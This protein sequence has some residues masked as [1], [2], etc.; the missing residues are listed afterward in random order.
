[1]EM[2]KMRKFNK[3]AGFLLVCASVALG[4]CTT[5]KSGADT[6]RAWVYDK[7]AER[8]NKYCEVRD[9]LIA[10]ALTDRINGGLTEAGFEGTVDMKVNCP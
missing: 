5:V 1:M 8:L 7:G 6:A 9:P 10:A 4:A 3:A 2:I